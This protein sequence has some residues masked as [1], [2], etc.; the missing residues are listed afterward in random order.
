MDA[1]EKPLSLCFILIMVKARF[2]KE[3][4]IYTMN[5]K[6]HFFFLAILFF[7][8]TFVSCKKEVEESPDMG[9]DYFPVEQGVF[10]SYQVESIIWDDNNQT[11]DTTYYQLRTEID[12]AFID[13]EG[14]MSYRWN[15]YTKTDTT[16]WKY[17]HT[18]AFTKTSSRLE[19]VEGNNR[20]VRLAFPVRLGAKWDVNAFNTK[21]KQ[22]AN[23]IDVD[24]SIKIGNETFDKCA[25]AL[26]EDNSSLVN[27]YY[28]EDVFARGVGLVKRVDTHIDKKLTGEI[29]KGYKKTYIAY[30]HGVISY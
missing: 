28:Q 8:M 26:L 14:R 24:A 18:Y 21:D 1:T 17:E 16:D 11:V 7:S 10:I 30:E 22:E 27:E 2:D 23:Y 15:R 19:T 25:I 13:N 29:T 20:Y 3:Q 4:S 9:S 5:I 12:T 6:I